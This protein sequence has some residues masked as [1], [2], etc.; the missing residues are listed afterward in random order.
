VLAEAKSKG[1]PGANIREMQVVLVH[2]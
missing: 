1:F 2:P